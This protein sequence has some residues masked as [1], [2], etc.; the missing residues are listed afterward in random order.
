LICGFCSLRFA[1]FWDNRSEAEKIRE[2]IAATP[3]DAA[4]ISF[5][6]TASIGISLYLP[7][8]EKKIETII[9][10][11]DEALADAKESG[12]N[13]CNVYYKSMAGQPPRAGRARSLDR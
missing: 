12:K 7:V 6:V 13:C 8:E 5:S 4:G 3:F 11:A 10:E 9:T 2:I 1:N